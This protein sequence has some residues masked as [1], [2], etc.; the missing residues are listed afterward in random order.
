MSWRFSILVAFL[1]ITLGTEFCALPGFAGLQ[2]QPHMVYSFDDDLSDDGDTEQER[3]PSG[4]DLPLLLAD[5]HLAFR[6]LLTG[7]ILSVK[8]DKSAHHVAALRWHRW[9]CVERC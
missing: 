9:I 7:M 2:D 8:G 6:S 3:L 1:V 5:T 4:L